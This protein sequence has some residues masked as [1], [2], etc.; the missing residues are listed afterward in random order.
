MLLIASYGNK[1]ALIS[2]GFSNTLHLMATLT[3]YSTYRTQLGAWSY[4]SG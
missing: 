3:G 2:Q 1:K 4:G